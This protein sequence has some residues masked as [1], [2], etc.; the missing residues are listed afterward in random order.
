MKFVPEFYDG[1]NAPICLDIRILKA[2]VIHTLLY[3][4]V[5]QSETL[6][7]AP[8]GSQQSYLASVWLPV[9]TSY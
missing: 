4:C 8:V 1:T 6:H 7:Q 3:A 9:A 5:T 2:E